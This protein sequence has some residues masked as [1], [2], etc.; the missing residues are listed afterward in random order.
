VA[1]V[2][3]SLFETLEVKAQLG[4]AFLPE[5]EALGQPRVAIISDALWRTRL[6]ADPS[7]LGRSLQLDRQAF[8]I[9]G[10]MPPLF[11]YPHASD[12]AYPDS[13]QKRTDVWLPLRL[14][15]AQKS[16]RALGG[17]G[18]A[19]ARLR[20]RVALRQAQVEMSAVEAQLDLLYPPDAR[21]WTA[22]L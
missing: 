8:T 12:V 21:G 9:V 14:N 1:S 16:D 10:V 18:T 15:A 19:I 3:A 11:A 13:P 4:R 7:V 17:G 5:D 20:P 6:G 22:Y 2:T